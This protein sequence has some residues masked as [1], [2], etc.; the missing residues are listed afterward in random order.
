MA[1]SKAKKTRLKQAREGKRSPESN[2]L[3]WNGIVPVERVTPTRDERLRKQENKHKKKW[4]RTL[5]TS[6]G[7]IFDSSPV[8]SFRQ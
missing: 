4:N 8:G 2:R 5:D 1:L 3:H 7:S 6:D